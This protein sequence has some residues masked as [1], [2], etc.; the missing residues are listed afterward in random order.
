M[1]NKRLLIARLRHALRQIYFNA[2]HKPAISRQGICKSRK[3]NIRAFECSK[4]SRR[5]AKDGL[6]IG[7][8]M[9]SN[10]GREFGFSLLNQYALTMVPKIL[11]YFFAFIFLAGQL[12]SQEKCSAKF[13][14]VSPEDFDLS[15]SKFDSSANAVIIADIGS[16]VFEGNNKGDFSLVFKRYKRIKILNRNGLD[17]A[18]ATISVYN[19]GY[20]EER[21]YELKATT[22]NLEDGKVVETKLDDKSVFTDKLD[23]ESSLKKFTLPAVKQGSIIEYSY[24]IKSDFYRHLRSWNFQGSYPIL[25]SEYT[26]TI[27]PYFHYVALNQGDQSFY[28]NNSKTVGASYNIRDENGSG[29]SEF[30]SLNGQATETRWVMKD[31]PA[32]K[33]EPFTTTIG[34]HVSRIEFQLHYIQYS[35]T[36]ERH[37]Y[38]G[39]WFIASEKLLSSEYFGKA[40]D[41]DNHWM[42]EEMKGVTSGCKTNLEKMKNIFEFVRK[43]FTCTSHDIIYAANP[44]KTVYKKKNGTVAEI[45]LLLTALM[46]HE[47]IDAD[48]MVLS[49]RDNGYSS[50]T[51]P[52]LERFNYVVCVARDQDQSYYLDASEPLNGFN[53][54]PEQCYN[55]QA[56]IINREKPYV[57]YFDADSLNEQKRTSVI[58]INNEK[59]QISGSLESTLGYYESY[60]LRSKIKQKS[61]ASFKNDLQTTLGSDIR[62]DSL[63]VDSLSLLEYPVKINYDFGLANSDEDIIYFNP[64]LAEGYKENPFKSAERRYPVEMPFTM[65]EIYTMTMEVPEKYQVEELPKSA[66]VTFNEN[67]GFFEYLIQKTDAGI[68]MRSRIKLNKAYFPPEEYNSLREFFAFI[69]NKQSEQIVFKKKK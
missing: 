32:L 18:N 50:E 40:L 37:D 33:E 41:D 47:K 16:S 21:L 5:E 22:Y 63:G 29:R 64:M 11:C 30:L 68:V 9:H 55:G 34:N 51:Y 39:N 4:S 23:R 15:K 19:D 60:D 65:D 44:L 36:T 13:G 38:M 25:W 24:T 20:S 28:I 59:G 8:R 62:V 57:V 10:R 69:V 52:L 14:K 7:N 45:N 66:K 42:S 56:R 27:P 1:T 53:H 58:I 31:V 48:P 2:T 35:E 61:L 43:N 12:Y 46:R 67:E 26:V 54:L 3:L 6:Y 17:V 49:T